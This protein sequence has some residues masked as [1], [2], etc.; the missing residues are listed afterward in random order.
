MYDE[1]KAKQTLSLTPTAVKG[2]D[3]LA[4][5]L[6][7]S[8]SEVVEQIGRGIIPLAISSQEPDDFSC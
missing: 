7:I 6:G 5:S 1:V 3:K 2:L 8:R 4:E